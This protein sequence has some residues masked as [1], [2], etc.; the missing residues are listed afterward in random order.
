MMKPVEVMML[1]H[2]TIVCIIGR[3]R[4]KNLKTQGHKAAFCNNPNYNGAVLL[5]VL[6]LFYS[7]SILSPKIHV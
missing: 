5:S 1:Y 7:F 3:N 2:V 6:Y 4:M